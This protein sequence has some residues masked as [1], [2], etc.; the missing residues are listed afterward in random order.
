MELLSKTSPEQGFMIIA[1]YQT[2]GKGQYGRVWES[3]PGKNLLCSFIFGPLALAVDKVFRLHLCSSLAIIDTLKPF[4]LPELKI[5]WPNDIYSGNKKISGILIQNTIKEQEVHYCI[6][7]VGINVNQTEFGNAPNAGSLKLITNLQFNR[8][9]LASQLR[10]H[11]LYYFRGQ[12]NDTKLLEEYNSLL[13]GLN[14]KFEFTS[15]DEQWSA[16]IRGVDSSGNLVL[17]SESGILKNYSFGSLQFN[18]EKA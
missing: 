6:V 1:D 3:E 10:A 11:L 13:Y 12:Q 17:E 18:H 8:A 9:D 4:R 15:N 2:A 16:Y 5:K 14:Q 7:G